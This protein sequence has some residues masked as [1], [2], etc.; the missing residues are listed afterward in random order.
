MGPGSPP[1]S[2]A[3]WGPAEAAP[4]Q[5]WSCLE[6]AAGDAA[7]PLGLAALAVGVVGGARVAGLV[8]QP[9][10][11]LAEVQVAGGQVVV[12]LVQGANAEDH[13]ANPGR[14][15]TQAIATCDIEAPRPSA[16]LRTASITRQVRS[17]WPR[18]FQIRMPW[19]IWSDSLVHA[20]GGSPCRY[21]PVSQ[22]LA[23]GDQGS[24][25][26]P[27]DWQAGPTSHSIARASRLYC[28]CTVTGRISPCASARS[29]YFWIW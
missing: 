16:T 14:A 23:S 29:T 20:A 15:C 8:E 28:G 4:R 6:A 12:E 2:A 18:S 22:P 19:S 3:A 11:V 27:S 25:P 21:L 7:V 10:L 13:R 9:R 1:R 17:R 26:S 24:R 5:R